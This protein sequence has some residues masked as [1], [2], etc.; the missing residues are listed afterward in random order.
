MEFIDIPEVNNSFIVIPQRYTDHRGHFQE[1]YNS[2]KYQYRIS[3]CQQV[4]FSV[5][6]K[7]TLRGI[8]TT[9]Y[10]KLVQ[11]LRGRVVDY[12]I[13]LRP[14]SS[15]YLKWESVVLSEYTSKQVYIPPFCGHAFFSCED[16][17]LLV[18]CQ[19]GVFNPQ[20][21][22]NV[23]PFDDKL[24]IVWPDAENY[25]MSDQDR[26]APNEKEARKMWEE[27]NKM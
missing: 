3:S 25:I 26:I 15:T 22:M 27:R 1:H 24:S 19:E 11:C 6:K 16:D 20:R 13:D 8:H 18:Y 7:N 4:S 12:V 10:G 17:S 5:S 2:E 9:P 21:E 23:N 14:S